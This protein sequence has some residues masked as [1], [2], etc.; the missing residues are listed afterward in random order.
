MVRTNSTM[1]PLGSPLPEFDLPKVAGT[2]FKEPNP[3]MNYQRISKNQLNDSPILIMT[4]CAHCPF[5]KHIEKGLSK[6]DQDYFDKVQILAIASN[7]L[8]T[9]PQD[10]PEYLAEQAQKNGWRFPYLLDTDQ[11]FAKDLKAAC[12]PDFFVFSSSANGEYLLRYRGQM[13]GSRPGND[14]EVTCEDLRKALDAILMGYPISNDQKPSIGCN[15]KWHPG[16]EPPWFG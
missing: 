9:H 3:L 10:G 2:G 15:I 14:I 7:S 4:I 16:E 11:N 6:L 8:K 5:V 12:T 13:D 1:L